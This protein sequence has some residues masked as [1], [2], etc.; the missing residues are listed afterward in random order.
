VLSV[1]Y[2]QAP[3][4]PFPAAVHDAVAATRWALGHAAGL[5]AD[6]ARVGVGGDSAGGNLA[7]VVAREL[8]G[9]DGP[10]LALQLLIYPGTDLTGSETR[11]A[12]LFGRGF[13]LD[14]ASREWC[15]DRYLPAGIDR[16]DP[17]VSPLRGDPLS[18]LAPAVVVTGAFDPLRDE[19]EAYA[20]A[21]TAAGNRV[22]SHR[23]EGLIHGFINL[24]T[25]N[26]RSRDAV[27]AL[28]GMARSE[29]A[30]R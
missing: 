20:A 29:L 24:T 1:A 11:S 14:D 2:R 13:Y 15:M 16:A 3:E 5:G 9:G 26:R 22:A 28:A 10:P 17:L 6:P 12:R 27:L 7:A 19:G 4:H 23:A 18:G 8:A 25:V 21:L 30:P